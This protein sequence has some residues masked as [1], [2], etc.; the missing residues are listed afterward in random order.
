MSVAAILELIAF[1]LTETPVVIADIQSLVGT[2][3][4]V[5]AGQTPSQEQAALAQ[6]IAARK[7][8]VATALGS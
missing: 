2:A 5:N 1:A 7:Q 4:A 6:A 3:Q 8:A